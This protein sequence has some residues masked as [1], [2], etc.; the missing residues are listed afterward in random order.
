MQR[1]TIKKKGGENTEKDRPDAHPLTV[2]RQLTVTQFTW[3][4]H[5]CTRYNSA[6]HL[7]VGWCEQGVAVSSLCQCAPQ[8]GLSSIVCF[9][10]DV[11]V[12]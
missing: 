2:S 3:N 11:V 1:K 7:G 9:H 12:I 8:V 10:G 4:R 6:Q 5:T